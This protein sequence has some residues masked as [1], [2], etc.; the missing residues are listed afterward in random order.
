[1]G[2][3]T[4]LPVVLVIIFFA[5]VLLIYVNFQG[6]NLTGVTSS[7]DSDGDGFNDD[8]DMFPDDENE[9]IDFDDD[10]IGDNSDVYINGNAGVKISIMGFHCEE[11][12][13]STPDIY[14]N[15]IVSVYDDDIKDF[16]KIGDKQSSV[17]NDVIEVYDPIYYVVDVDDDVFHVF[18]EIEAWDQESGSQID[19]YGKSTS[20][21]SASGSFY[22]QI[23]SNS[24]YFDDGQ[25]DSVA[26]EF[27]GWIDFTVE[28][29]EI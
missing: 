18:V 11:L 14:F 19:L 5:A 12:V 16:V 8:V 25:L 2:E 20:I 1:M 24:S 29:V 9:W 6:D 13:S 26:D 28:L 15:I 27:D 23:K 4:I 3:K 7:K 22:P 17:Y 10:G 21:F